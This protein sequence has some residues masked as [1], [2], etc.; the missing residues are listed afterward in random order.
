MTVNQLRAM[1][2]ARPFKPFRIHMADGRGIDVT[3]PE[4]VAL[5]SGGRTIGV[6]TAPDVI[7]VVDLLLVTSLEPLTNGR[8]KSKRRGQRPI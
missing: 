6:A 7:E 3:H 4:L 8:A 1:H 2:Q 5:T